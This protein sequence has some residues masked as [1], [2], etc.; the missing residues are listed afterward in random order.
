[1]LLQWNKY[2]H[3]LADKG[4]KILESL[5]TINDPV[6]RGTTIIYELPNEGSK[7]EFESAK[8]DLLGHLRGKLHNYDIDI[9]VIVNEAVENKFAFTP[10]DKYNRL[11]EINPNLDLLRKT[12]DLDF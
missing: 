8:H 3:K 11:N 2:A 1:M 9:E 5:M 4:Q 7:I 12:F 10:Q 6:L